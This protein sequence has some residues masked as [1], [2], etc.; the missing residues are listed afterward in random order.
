MRQYTFH[1]E[2]RT[3]LQQFEQAFNDIVIKRFNA[4]R[5]AQDRLHVNF[6]YMPKTR[7]LHDLV[8]KA[9]HIKLPCVS[10]V[11]AGMRRDNDRVFNKLDG[12]YYTDTARMS[13]WQHLLQPVP[14][15]LQVNMSIIARYSMD[16]DQILTNFIP[17]TDP[18]IVVST[19]WPDPIPWAD[20]EVRSRIQWSG[21]VNVQ[22]PVDITQELPYRIIADTSFTIGTWMYKNSPGPGK[23]IYYIDTSYTS[24]SDIYSYEVHREETNEYNTDFWGISA[25]PQFYSAFPYM[26]FTTC[27]G[28]LT[29]LSCATPVTQLEVIGN[30]F[31]FTREIYLSGTPG[32][33]DMTW[34]PVTSVSGTSAVNPFWHDLFGDVPSLSA[35]YPGFSGVAVPSA[36]WYAV[37]ENKILLTVSAHDAGFFDIIAVN[38][39]GYGKLTVDSIRHTPNP[40]T[41]GTPEY[42]AFEPLQRPTVSGIEVRSFM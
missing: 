2:I 41:P 37:D 18:Y 38:A 23:P 14:I 12:S 28:P 17:Y 34:N 7:V 21:Q 27:T 42:D 4:D 8:N 32:V 19:K 10:I 31:D 13:A 9:Q 25:R 29:A 39:A 24:V 20:F 26:M 33:F 30:M 1:W 16:V 3:I 6:V 15:D 35:F 5:A 36:H 40:Y 11:Q 22:Y